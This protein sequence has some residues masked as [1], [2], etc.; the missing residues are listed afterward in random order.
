MRAFFKQLL[1][2]C[3]TPVI[4]TAGAE[5]ETILSAANI[6]TSAH[7][8]RIALRDRGVAAGDVVCGAPGPFEAAVDFVACCIGGFTYVPLGPESLSDLRAELAERP[9]PGRAGF[10]IIQA[11]GIAH[12]P[13]L[14]PESLAA[15]HD[16]PQ[17]QLALLPPALAHFTGEQI[18]RILERLSCEL[19]TPVGAS[20]L[21]RR[22]ALDD[23]GFISDFLLA[24]ACRQTI[25]W[26]GQERPDEAETLAEIFALRIDDLV[27]PPALLAPFDHVAARLAEDTRGKLSRVRLHTGGEALSPAQRE[28]AERLFATVL[29]EPPFE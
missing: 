4:Q 21:T 16:A 5:G 20:R 12:H 2:G 7:A 11:D 28:I 13:A 17:A 6:W 27:L 9:A 1:K 19:A 10:A 14:L 8:R 24:L 3:G 23:A 22:G 26:R 18:E 29:I 15:L 25:H